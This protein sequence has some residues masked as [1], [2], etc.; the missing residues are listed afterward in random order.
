MIDT[1]RYQLMIGA[2][3]LLLVVAFSVYLYL[4]GN[5]GIHQESAP[6]SRS[7][8]SWRRWPPAI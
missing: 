3:R 6:A 7:S 2:H 8:T 1:R 4:N 5:R